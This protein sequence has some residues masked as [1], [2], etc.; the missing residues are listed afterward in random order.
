VRIVS[1]NCAMALH[2]KHDRLLALDSDVSVIQECSK[3]FVEQ[4]AGH[5]GWSSAWFGDRNKTNK[6]LGVVV[7]SP[8]RIA[9]T[10]DLTPKW[11]GRVLLEGPN[12]LEL[13]PV[14]AHVSKN[15]AKEYIE[16]VHL[17]LDI[18]ES[19]KLLP[20]AI[21]LGDSNSNSLWDYSYGIY[22]HSAAV[23]R[24]GSLGMESAYHKFSG[25]L[26][27]GELQPTLWFR[28]NKNTTYHIDYAFLSGLLMSKLKAVSIGHAK[29]WLMFSDH[30]PLMID[31]DLQ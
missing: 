24:F 31:F 29:D 19:K 21:V 23:A 13:F 5:E 27:G 4:I 26:Q 20:M 30:A 16:Q 3:K 15:P 7:R 2:K 25:D 11:T 28:K 10:E 8:W 6:G 18:L 9:A 17:L 1:W 14:W 22:S 12:A